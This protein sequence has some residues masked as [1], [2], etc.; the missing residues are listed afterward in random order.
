M[1][2]LNRNRFGHLDITRY[3]SSQKP[4]LASILS[5]IMN[6][7]LT[8]LQRVVIDPNFRGTAVLPWLFYYAFK[9]IYENQLN[10]IGS[11]SSKKLQTVLTKYFNIKNVDEE[12]Y[13]TENMNGPSSVFYIETDDLP[14]VLKMVKNLINSGKRCWDPE[15]RTRM[16]W[17]ISR[18]FHVFLEFNDAVASLVRKPYQRKQCLKWYKRRALSTQSVTSMCKKSKA[19]MDSQDASIRK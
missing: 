3:P 17:W 10:V 4:S 5:P 8:E 9:D 13:Y 1:R 19:E 2:R 14:R 16:Y 12:F 11:A 6:P 15:V 18:K 7:R